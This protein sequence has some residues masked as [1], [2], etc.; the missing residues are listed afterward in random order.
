MVAS[1]YMVASL[2][3]STDVYVYMYI[4]GSLVN[5]HDE[6]TILPLVSIAA[7]LLFLDCHMFPLVDFNPIVKGD[8]NAIE[9]VQ[10]STNTMNH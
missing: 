7:M 3:L 6:L 4:L 8:P 5:H 1:M 10:L 9:P 2:S